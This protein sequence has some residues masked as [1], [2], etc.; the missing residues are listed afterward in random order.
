M[1]RVRVVAIRM[2]MLMLVMRCCMTMTMP[3]GGVGAV[4]RLKRL[5]DRLH[6][7]VHGAQHVGQHV[8]GFNLQVGGLE[9]DGHMAVTQVVGGAEPHPSTPEQFAAF[10]RAETTKWAKVVKDSNIKAD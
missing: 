9:L 2:V 5:L 8:V 7:Q 1:A 10:M 4:L 6:D 3:A